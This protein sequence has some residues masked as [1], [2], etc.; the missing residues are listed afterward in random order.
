MNLALN[1][2]KSNQL[3][4]HPTILQFSGKLWVSPESTFVL[5]TSWRMSL[6]LL[7]DVHQVL[8]QGAPGK[9]DYTAQFAVVP[10]YD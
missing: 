6:F 3:E 2:Q 10:Q 4:F 9:F 7:E 5:R 1:Q 8:F